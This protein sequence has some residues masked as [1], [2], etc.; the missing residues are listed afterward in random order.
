MAGGA[1]AGIAIANTVI[2]IGAYSAQTD[3]L[4]AQAKG[5][6][7]QEK[8]YLEQGAR[9]LK[10]AYETAQDVAIEGQAEMG[11]MTA[12]FGKQGSLLEGSPLLVIAEAVDRIFKNTSRIIEQGW[13][14]YRSYFWAYRTAHMNKEAVQ[15][16]ETAAGWQLAGNIVNDW[17]S[18]YGMGG[19]GKDR[20]GQA[21]SISGATPQS[22]SYNQPISG[23]KVY[24]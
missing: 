18:A 7:Y 19:G 4:R 16:A 20:G 9:A 2:D 21:G 24:A 11:E 22:S 5:Y 8:Y 13:A 15:S 3:A 23:Q 1:A 6:E 10:Q 17:A 12:A 14:D